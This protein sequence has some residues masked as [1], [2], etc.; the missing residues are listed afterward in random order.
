MR[1]K[2]SYLLEWW[3]IWSEAGLLQAVGE[4][5][6]ACIAELERHAGRRVVIGSEPQAA[7]SDEI[8]YVA[9]EPYHK[10]SLALERRCCRLDLE[11]GALSR[12]AAHDL[13]REALA[14]SDCD[15][16]PQEVFER[17]LERAHGDGWVATVDGNPMPRKY[18]KCLKADG[19]GVYGRG[20][21]H[22]PT[23]KRPGKWMPPTRGDL[24]L[25]SN[26]YHACCKKDLVDWLDDRIFEVAFRGE[27][28]RGDN[29]VVG[30][31][32]RLVRELHW[33][34]KI[35]RLFACDCAERVLPLF[36]ARFPDDKRPRNA[37]ETARRFVNRVTARDR[38][39]A[40]WDAAQA[41]AWAAWAAARAAAWAAWT[42]RAAAGEA[43]WDA[44][45]AA[46]AAGAAGA[47]ARAAGAAGAAEAAWTAWTAAQAA[48]GE[49]AGDAERR[50]Q[51]KRLFEYLERVRQS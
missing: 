4:T 37:I 30:R 7:P 17:I 47:A 6:A 19:S 28:I 16:A 1:K 43:A 46:W 29:K 31:E 49:A 34:A 27:V 39:A 25:C 10:A 13:L 14:E 50:W 21:W 2:Q 18:Y 24:A 23:G 32:A 41:A 36:E 3:E 8:A 45:A 38:L 35:A 44:R 11:C 20:K 42:A 26:G 5:E 9:S 51:T 22:L 33:D 48:A 12:E 15:C 40:A